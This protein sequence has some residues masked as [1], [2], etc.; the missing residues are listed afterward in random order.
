LRE[1]GYDVTSV[2]YD[3]PHAYDPAVVA[4]GVDFVLA[5]AESPDGA[6]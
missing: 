2:E 3:G 6:A 4:R 1:A 5:E